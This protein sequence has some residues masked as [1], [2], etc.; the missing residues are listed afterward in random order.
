MRIVSVLLLVISIA[1]VSGQTRLTS[2][3]GNQESGSSPEG[4]FFLN[5]NMIFSAETNVHG[6]ELWVTDGASNTS[7]ISNIGPG[8]RS[9]ISSLKDNAVVFQQWLYFLAN[10]HEEGTTLWRTDGT[11]SGTENHLNLRGII[12]KTF[13]IVEN[14]LYFLRKEGSLVE[15][16]KDETGSDGPVLVKSI[17]EP[18]HQIT[19][20][21]TSNGIFYFNLIHEGTNGSTFWKSDG[22]EA[23]TTKISSQIIGGT[24]AWPYG[25]SSPAHLFSFKNEIYFMSR[26]NQLFTNPVNAGLVKINGVGDSITPVI[27]MQEGSLNPIDFEDFILSNDKLYILQYQFKK[28]RLFIWESDGTDTG[29]QLIYE[30][31]SEYD[32]IPSNLIAN[33]DHLY[34]L[35][36]T[37]YGNPALMKLDVNSHDASLEK[38]INLE[39]TQRAIFLAEYDVARISSVGDDLYHISFPF[40]FRNYAGFISDLS[41]SGT[42]RYDQ[43]DNTLEITSLNDRLIFA[44][45]PTSS[46]MEL[47]STSKD[48][49]DFQI[50]EDIA[51]HAVSIDD[52]RS[53]AVLNNNIFLIADNGSMG[54]EPWLYE[55]E[56][57][58]TRLVK[59]INPG[60]ASSYPVGWTRHG[61]AYFFR[62]VT[63]DNGH[64]LWK[65][66]GSKTG[67]SLFFDA[68]TM[69]SGY[70]AGIVSF[71]NDLY[72]SSESNRT[73]YFYKF[74]GEKVEPIKNLGSVQY[75]ASHI[76]STDNHMYFR[77]SSKLMRYDGLSD[78]MELI[79]FTSYNNNAILLNDAIFFIGSNNGLWYSPDGSGLEAH[80]VKTSEGA[81]VQKPEHFIRFHNYVVFSAETSESGRELWRSDGT[82][83]GT[84]QIMDIHPGPTSGIKDPHFCVSDDQLFFTANDG[85]SGEEIWK[86]DGTASNTEMLI[87]I[88]EGQSRAFIQEITSFDDTLYFSAYT[89]DL[90]HQ[91]Y[92]SDGTEIGTHLL[93]DTEDGI[94]FTEPQKLRMID[95]ELYFLAKSEDYG[96]QLWTSATRNTITKDLEKEITVAHSNFVKVFP[97]PADDYISINVRYPTNT[98]ISVI[99]L[100]GQ[101]VHSG[102]YTQELNISHLLPGIYNLV[103]K[104]EKGTEVTKFMKN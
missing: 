30:Q 45:N 40:K 85:I 86:S 47:Y 101:V 16:W 75:Y 25:T 80:E 88:N 49:T 1:V 81:A 74:D 82:P 52:F 90:G 43:L 17:S 79:G 35:S 4:F 54:S 62:A 27:A 34:F 21:A 93:F 70:P 57:G 91:L 38:E 83:E 26:N 78:D 69:G 10:D 99:N 100:L 6:R 2:F 60:S 18:V 44:S 67:T 15:L 104:D 20:T 50:V 98:R 97:N 87:D 59:D 3:R 22:S 96:W 33:N 51:Q 56:N 8:S 42:H 103:V 53:M 102:E 13:T 39:I 41:D 61:D 95:G 94:K 7:R 92:I 76:G 66:D 73:I 46:G 32:I 64:E 28:K 37:Q 89:P 72:F 11:E 5:N 23:G 12:G 84:Y 29:S 68:D 71:K 9:A 14:E 36:V 31:E 55:T 65:S 19:C 24:G 58:T 77:S 48:M 63:E